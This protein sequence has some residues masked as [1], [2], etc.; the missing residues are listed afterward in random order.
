MKRKLKYLAVYIFTVMLIGSIT[1][2]FSISL[3]TNILKQ[4][5]FILFYTVL[6]L[7]FSIVPTIVFF[8]KK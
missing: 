4:P 3:D 7:I 8:V 6:V 2:W 5:G 1:F